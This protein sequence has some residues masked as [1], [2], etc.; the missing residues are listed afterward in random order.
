M[1]DMTNFQ[2]SQCTYN[3]GDMGKLLRSMLEDGTLLSE[4]ITP[5]TYWRIHKGIVFEGHWRISTTEKEEG[6]QR[7]RFITNNHNT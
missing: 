1:I 6:I 2:C 4:I 7:E 5:E 3:F